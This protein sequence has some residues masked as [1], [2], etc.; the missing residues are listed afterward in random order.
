MG[1]F[2]EF[3]MALFL[4]FCG[5]SPL[6]RNTVLM[7]EVGRDDCLGW[8]HCLRVRLEFGNEDKDRSKVIWQ[9]ILRE[10]ASWDIL[11]A[12]MV[13]MIWFLIW[14]CNPTVWKQ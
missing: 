13:A 2:K 8:Q 11:S 7:R 6:S 12:V 10:S 4:L 3:L 1:I 14:M 9:S 5:S